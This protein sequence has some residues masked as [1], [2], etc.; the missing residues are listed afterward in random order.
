MHEGF[1]IVD[2]DGHYAEPAD[3]FEGRLIPST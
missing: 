2:A 1:R 3:V